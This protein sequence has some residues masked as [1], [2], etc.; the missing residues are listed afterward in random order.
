MDFKN[1][2]FLVKSLKEGRED[3]YLFLLNHYDRKLYAYALSLIDDHAIA[4]DILQNVF[5]KIWQN[6]KKLNIHS[7]LHSYLYKS[8]YYEFVN[9]YR[10]KQNLSVL[11]KKYT[12]SLNRVVENIED[13]NIE[14]VIA[15][16]SKE[17]SKLPPKCKEIF[18]LSKKEGLSNNEISEYLGLSIK[19]VEGQIT[20]AFK[21]LRAN[22]S[23]KVKPLLF[24]VFGNTFFYEDVARRTKS[25]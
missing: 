24:L 23:E 20:K 16:V 3:A 8:V 2:A 11:E 15:L 25:K 18:I 17:T 7:S 4:Q 21:I 9:Q 14:N 12:E 19:T 10:A 1:D 5:L 22:L 6:R 13:T